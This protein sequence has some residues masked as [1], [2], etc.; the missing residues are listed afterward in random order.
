MYRSILHDYDVIYQ[1]TD[2]ALI[3][4]EEY[5]RFKLEKPELL[6]GEFG[7]LELEPGSNYY[8]SYVTIAPKNYFI[9]G[10]G[11]AAEP[12]NDDDQIVRRRLYKKGFKGVSLERDKYIRDIE[13]PE[14][15]EFVYK[16]THRNGDVSYYIKD[17][18]SLYHNRP[19][20]VKTVYDDCD[21]FIESMKVNKKAYILTS[22]ISK[23]MRTTSDGMQ[24]GGVYGRFLLKKISVRE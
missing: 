24:A 13:S 6:G 23:S 16:T 9:F 19:D 8:N 11:P 15:Q 12:A 21:H 2:S 7:Q 10:D 18:F 3:S 14:L 20:L 4:G 5:K 17:A 1:D 22:S